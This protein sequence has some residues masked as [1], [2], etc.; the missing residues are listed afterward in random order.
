MPISLAAQLAL[1]HNTTS[2]IH[3]ATHPVTSL[4]LILTFFFPD[5]NQPTLFLPT[6]PISHHNLLTSPKSL[7]QCYFPLLSQ[8][9][10]PFFQ[11]FACN[12]F[13][14]ESSQITSWIFCFVSDDLLFCIVAT[15]RLWQ[16]QSVSGWLHCSCNPLSPVYTDSSWAK[17]YSISTFTSQSWWWKQQVWNVVYLTSLHVQYYSLN[18]HLM[19]ITA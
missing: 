13:H 2:P 11:E 5:L 10:L 12:L 1:L 14:F 18:V 4:S 17:R 15:H 19:L 8:F 3:P 6:H 16:R 9:L 7:P